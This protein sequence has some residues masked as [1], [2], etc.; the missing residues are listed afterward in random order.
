MSEQIQNIRTM[1][2]FTLWMI[3]SLDTCSKFS[4][5]RGK[6]HLATN[7]AISMAR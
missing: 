7:L 3:K 2:N 5:G 4:S 1:M 6:N